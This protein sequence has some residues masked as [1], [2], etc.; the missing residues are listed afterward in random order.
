MEKQKL[1]LELNKPVRLKLMY[2]EPRTGSSQYGEYFLYSLT[3]GEQEYSFFANEKTHQ[4]MSHLG[5]G[6]T[7][8]LIKLASQRGKA[9]ITEIIATGIKNGNGNGNGKDTK[10]VSKP[11]EVIKPD[12]PS[13]DKLFELMLKSLGD[14]IRMQKLLDSKIDVERIGITLFIARSRGNLS[15]VA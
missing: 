14:S 2:D 1:T 6:E 8:E 13:E 10:S 7:V 3:D 15:A 4:Q 5:R 9:V 12:I 11:D